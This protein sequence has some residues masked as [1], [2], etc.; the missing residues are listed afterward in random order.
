[1]NETIPPSIWMNAAFTFMVSE[2]MHRFSLS[3]A[4]T[5]WFEI[6]MKLH[7]TDVY[8]LNVHN[9]IVNSFGGYVREIK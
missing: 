9:T 8:W 3:V 4:F 2:F 7:V 6:E 1:M 5:V